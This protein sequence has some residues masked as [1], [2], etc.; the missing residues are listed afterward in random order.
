MNNF[1]QLA[2]V[3]G[4][5]FASSNLDPSGSCEDWAQTA[6]LDWDIQESPVLFNTREGI[7]TSSEDKVLYRSDNLELTIFNEYPP[8][9][10]HVSTVRSSG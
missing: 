4:G 3:G 9:I 6:G 8:S 2:L 10:A 5:R 7:L 1:Q